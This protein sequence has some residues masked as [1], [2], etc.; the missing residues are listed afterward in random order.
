MEKT[1]PLE[2]E[3]L[4]DRRYPVFR[5]A[6]RGIDE[7]LLKIYIP[8]TIFTQVF[9]RMEPFQEN[10]VSSSLRQ[11][12]PWVSVADQLLRSASTWTGRRRPVPAMIEGG[13]NC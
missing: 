9:R 13:E 8:L 1:A 10:S 5:T 7:T 4:F 11:R 2:A 6:L 3:K 12:K